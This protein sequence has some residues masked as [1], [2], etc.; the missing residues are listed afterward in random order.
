VPHRWIR[1]QFTPDFPDTQKGPAV[2]RLV[3]PL[4]SLLISLLISPLISALVPVALLAV[5]PA[6]VSGKW[7]V[8]ANI[9]GTA[10]ELTCTFAQ[11]EAELSGTCAG[12]QAQLAVTGKVDNKT[13][14]WQFNTMWEG[15]TLTVIYSGTIEADKISGGVDV[16]PLGVAGEFTATKAP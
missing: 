16:Q 4:L 1:I 3:A 12:D 14:T 7:K 10:S 6:S 13:V 5:Q 2:K 9:A 8:S 11:K 15:Q